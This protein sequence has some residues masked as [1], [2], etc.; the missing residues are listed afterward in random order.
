MMEN[1]NV[2]RISVRIVMA[3]AALAVIVVGL[4]GGGAGVLS[5]VRESASS[6]AAYAVVLAVMLILAA[7]SCAV[8]GRWLTHSINKDL[9]KVLEGLTVISD[10]IQTT[11]SQLRET[12]ES[13]ADGS[14]KQAASIEETSATMNQT[15][16][17]VDQNAE[18][19]RQAAQLSGNA[20]T[21]SNTGM[22]KMDQ[23]V[24]SMEELKKS[25]DMI[26][27][28]IKTIEDI[29]FQ[30]NL[31]AINATIEAAQAGEAGRGFAVVADEVRTLARRSAN[32]ASET[33]EI[34]NKNIE[35]TNHVMQTSIEVAKNLKQVNGEF[36][37][38]NKIIDE[39]D[40]A[41]EEQA[42]GIRQINEAMNDMERLTQYNAASAEQSAASASGLAD[43]A[44]SLFDQISLVTSLIK[45]SDVTA[46]ASA[47][48]AQY[49]AGP[50]PSYPAKAAQRP[51]SGMDAAPAKRTSPMDKRATELEKI[52][53]LEDD[54]D[55]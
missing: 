3:F 33:T 2:K 6:S 28:I 10:N 49:S 31:L 52:I 18:N 14:N 13:L 7:G 54:N 42:K 32:A 46:P 47:W 35:L 26:S 40:A 51:V 1:K 36:D 50:S 55:F 5:W 17:M 34:I 45:K 15:S 8:V 9:N 48:P 29:S 20:I 19:T 12:S 21:V 30:T 16:S 43:E 41:S 38:L 11:S 24:A 22:K 53:P 27:K 4:G 23:M 25:S 44:R 37:S 39:I